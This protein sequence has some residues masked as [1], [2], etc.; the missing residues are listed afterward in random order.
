MPTVVLS[1]YESGLKTL[2]TCTHKNGG[3]IAKTQKSN[4][5]KTVGKKLDEK[6]KSVIGQEY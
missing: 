2:K 3:K 6:K 5:Q 4:K 1:C